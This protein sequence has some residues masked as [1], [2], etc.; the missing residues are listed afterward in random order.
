MIDGLIE[1]RGW[2]QQRPLELDQLPFRLPWMF[3]YG[4]FFLSS[5]SFKK[6]KKKFFFWVLP[7]LT[8]SALFT[9]PSPPSSSPC[10]LFLLSHRSRPLT[11]ESRKLH[12]SRSKG[13]KNMYSCFSSPAALCLPPSSSSSMHSSPALE[14][15]REGERDKKKETKKE[16]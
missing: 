4:L 1:R 5:S 12:K 9:F 8:H 11:R 15:N 3:Y 7:S 6:E 2:R 10:L 13:G 16:L 14:K